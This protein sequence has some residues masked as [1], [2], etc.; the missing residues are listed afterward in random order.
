MHIHHLDHQSGSI[1]SLHVCAI[2]P[3]VE[4]T[5]NQTLK[6]LIPLVFF[7]IYV[8]VVDCVTVTFSLCLL[9]HVLVFIQERKKVLL[10]THSHI[11]FRDD[12]DGLGAENGS[13][14]GTSDGWG[15]RGFA[16]FSSRLRRDA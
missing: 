13:D 1:H 7:N 3:R 4:R 14:S 6:V 9:R 10:N 2:N 11:H 15:W 16:G 12:I 8:G 5:V